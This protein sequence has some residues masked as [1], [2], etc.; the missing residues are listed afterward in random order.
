MT[1][2]VTMNLTQLNLELLAGMESA[3]KAGLEDEDLVDS[4]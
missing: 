2:R 1:L 3:S 4:A